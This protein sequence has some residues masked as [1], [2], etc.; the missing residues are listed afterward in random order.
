MKRAAATIFSA[1][2]C[3][4][5]G[6]LSLFAQND[7]GIHDPSGIVKENDR[8]YTF[9]TSNGVECTYST[10]L[11]TWRRGDRVFPSGFPEWIND[12]VS[13]FR[14]HFWAPAVF[15]MNNLWHVYFSCSTFGSRV[16][17]IGLATSPSLS[18]P[19]WEDQGMVVFTDNSSDHNAIDPDIMRHDGKIWLVYGSFWSGIVMTELDTTTGKPI[20]REDLHYVAGGNPEAAFA[21][22]HGDYYYLFFNRGKCCE[23][24][25]STY[26]IN[27][28]RSEDPTGPFLDKEGETTSS[29]GGTRILETEGRFIG[30]GHFGYFMENGREYMSYHYYD[31]NQNGASKLKISTLSWEDEWPEVNTD[32]DPCNPPPL[33]DCAGVENGN[34]YTDK[35]GICVGGTTD[36]LPCT[37]YIEGEE[38]V[39]FDGAMENTNEGYKG[40]G[41]FSFDNESGSSVSWELC[42]DTETTVALIFRYANGSDN[43]RDVSL[44]V[45]GTQQHESLE[46]PSTGSGADWELLDADVSLTAENNLITVTSLTSEGGPDIDRIIFSDSSVHNCG[47]GIY[48]KDRQTGKKVGCVSYAEGV[49]T[50]HADAPGNVS[51]S[52]Y[53]VSGKIVQKVIMKNVV[54][55]HNSLKLNTSMVSRGIYLLVMEQHPASL[56]HERL[57]SIW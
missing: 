47:T 16:S 30:P 23:G 39:A 5:M 31:G 11:C 24:V 32:F 26:Y 12:Y 15:Y 6:T 53:T 33:I 55:G 28:G 38:A 27:V 4:I 9:Y 8:Y 48:T 43:S 18:D 56:R 13:G 14:G 36:L 25:N 29:G 50:F 57:I 34:A 46:F 20:D 2:L 41:Y 45:N 35:C 54:R 44:A 19:E 51:I 17:A 7:Y 10:D 40:D 1:L 37:G 3:I 22:H 21:I 49:V 42:A 52:L